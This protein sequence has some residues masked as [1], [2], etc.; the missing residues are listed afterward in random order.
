MRPRSSRS[1]RDHG[2]R[3]RAPHPGLQAD[4]SLERVRPAQEDSQ[5]R[6][7]VRLDTPL[8]TAEAT[9][10]RQRALLIGL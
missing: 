7:T 9:P 4:S 10:S 1:R 8:G 2:E 3:A 6:L 5:Q